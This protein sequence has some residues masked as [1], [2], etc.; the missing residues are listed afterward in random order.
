MTIVGLWD[1]LITR[2]IKISCYQ[3]D[4]VIK[5]KDRN[6]CLVIDIGKPSNYNIQNEATEKINKQADLKIQC[7]RMGNQNIDV[8]PVIVSPTP[9]V[10]KNLKKFLSRIP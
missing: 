5:E 8:V 2:E 9:K 6:K 10:E 3:L 7:K 1:S 4:I